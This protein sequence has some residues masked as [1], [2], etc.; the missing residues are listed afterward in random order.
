LERATASSWSITH[1]TVV[2][3]S[4]ASLRFNGT[5]TIVVFGTVFA[6]PPECEPPTVAYFLDSLPP[7]ITTLPRATV[8]MLNQP[9]YTSPTLSPNEEHLLVINVTNRTPQSRPYAL[10][11]FFL[12]PVALSASSTQSSQGIPPTT[13]PPT[14]TP[15]TATPPTATLTTSVIPP[16]V[17]ASATTMPNN[18]IIGI[19]AGVVGCLVFIFIVGI[20]SSLITRWRTYARRELSEEFWAETRS[21]TVY[22]NFTT[23]ES[24]LRHDPSIWNPTPSNE[25]CDEASSQVPQPGE[26]SQ[27]T[28]LL[29]PSDFAQPREVSLSTIEFACPSLSSASTL[30]L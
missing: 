25:T 8:D 11:S 12:S 20:V 26:F 10:A 3:G 4:T 7:Y 2:E 17:P 29:W 24:I 9:L 23:S 14:T 21:E 16:T 30:S 15:P 18:N 28:D 19:V 13:T 27:P 5:S 1:T 6:I 22:S